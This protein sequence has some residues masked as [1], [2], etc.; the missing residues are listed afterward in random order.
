MPPCPSFYT[1]P[2]TIEEL[3]DTVVARVLDQLGIKSNLTPRWNPDL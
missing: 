1:F 3:A 2:E